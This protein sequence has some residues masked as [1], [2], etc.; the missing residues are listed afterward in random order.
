MAFPSKK[1]GYQVVRTPAPDEVSRIRSPQGGDAYGQNSGAGNPSSLPPGKGGAQSLLGQNMRDSV[2][3]PVMDQI[4]RVGVAGRGDSIPADDSVQERPVSD[5]GYSP[6]FGA[7]RQQADLSTIGRPSLP[8][9][10][11]PGASDADQRRQM[12]LKRTN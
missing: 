8:A 2:D 6:T 12:A 1:R 3:D 7:K 11:T 9:T 5:R 4:L 10:T